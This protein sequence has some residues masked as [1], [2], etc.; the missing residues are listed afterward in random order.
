MTSAL[1]NGSKDML[2]FLTFDCYQV[3]SLLDRLVDGVHVERS[4]GP[5]V[6]HLHRDSV[7]DEKV[8]SVERPLVAKVV[9]MH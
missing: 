5:H 9:L 7:L 6:D 2:V 1:T 4:D 8:G 3:V